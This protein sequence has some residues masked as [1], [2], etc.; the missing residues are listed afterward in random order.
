MNREAR[1]LSQ[2]YFIKIVFRKRGRE[3]SDGQEKR[4][5]GGGGEGVRERKKFN[6]LRDIM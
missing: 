1:L 2:E 6:K 5:A 4:R 3:K